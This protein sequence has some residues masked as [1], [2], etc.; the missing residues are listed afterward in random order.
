MVS[1]R[2]TRPLRMMSAEMI[3][4]VIE[5]Y[6]KKMKTRRLELRQILTPSM[7]HWKPPCGTSL[8]L[9]AFSGLN[10]SSRMLGEGVDSL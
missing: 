4:T 9:V 8:G 1:E 7:V 2:E 3:R 10:V 6:S 5:L